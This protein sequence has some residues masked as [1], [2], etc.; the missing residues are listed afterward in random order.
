MASFPTKRPAK[1]PAKRK[2]PAFVNRL[3]FSFLPLFVVTT[4]FV[5][6]L[7]ACTSFPA[8]KSSLEV[9]ETNPI[10]D[11]KPPASARKRKKIRQ[12]LQ[13][14][15]LAYLNENLTTPLDNNA[16]FYYLNVLTID[17]ENP[18]STQGLNDIV[19]RYLDLAISHA[20]RFELKIASDF[21][22]KA[23]SVGDNHPNIL[24]V[25]NRIDQQK[26]LR[27]K[28]Y[29][30]SLP[31]LRSRSGNLSHKLLEIG[32]AIARHDAIVI[33]SA[34]SDA[35]GRWIYQQLNAADENRV[36]AEF[37][38]GDQPQVRIFY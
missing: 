31:Q 33:I 18:D 20:N 11:Y 2:I 5:T 15:E 27:S 1:G 22:M 19:E 30:L 13:K 9:V 3:L 10:S 36:K 26:S 38:P 37:K 29:A 21:L 17:P 14:A 4:V 12:L 6:L 8:S 16:Y 32:R 35:M 7:P 25:K 34:P 28:K 24:A 23:R